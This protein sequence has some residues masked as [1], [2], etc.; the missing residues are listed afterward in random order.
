[1]V[2]AALRRYLRND[3]EMTDPDEILLD[4]SKP[5]LFAHRG[6]RGDAPENTIEAFSLAISKGV[7][8]IES[9]VWL[10]SDGAPILSHN[11]TVGVFGRRKKISKTLVSQLPGGVPSFENFYESFGSDLEVSLDIKDP[12]AIDAAISVA[13][14]YDA[15]SKLWIC[16]PDWEISKQWRK[17]NP[18]FKLVDSPGKKGFPEGGER[19]AFSLSQNG[20]D[21]INLRES[22][23]TAGYVELFH[24]YGLKCFAWDAHLP[25][26][27]DRAL[28]LGVDGIYSDYSDRML[29]AVQNY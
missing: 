21:A 16:Y 8:G 23:W 20:F 22:D 15:I 4:R 13:I 10:S 11:A 24:K 25:R 5:I 2:N 17:I 18:D 14:K 28:S 6:G 3:G 7:G 29:S 9:D 27:I 19:R 26:Q 12:E 1:V